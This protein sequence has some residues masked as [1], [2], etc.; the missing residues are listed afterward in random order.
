MSISLGIFDLFTYAVP[1]AL[2]LTVLLYAAQRLGWADLPG[3]LAMPSGVLFVGL[4]LASYLIG[5]LVYSAGKLA[6]RLPPHRTGDVWENA[7]AT[8]VA[9]TPGAKRR[10]FVSSDPNL[11]LA[12]LQMH[13]REAAVEI[14]RL[15]AA[16]LMLRSSALP[17]ALGAVIALVELALAPRRLDLAAIA[18]LLGGATIMSVRRSVQLR[19][20][21]RSKTLQ[22]AYWLPSIDESV[23]GAPALAQAAAVD[24]EAPVAITPTAADVF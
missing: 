24:G 3:L 14:S 9:R 1:G 5:H 18:L 2:Q 16:G 8:F 4:A 11:L 23:M 21:A 15:R 10:A 22:L 19:T 6:D 12:A 7:R 20:W 13:A 17:L